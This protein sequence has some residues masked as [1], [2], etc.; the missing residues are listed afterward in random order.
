[1]QRP[2]SRIAALGATSALMLASFAG[3][4]ARTATQTNAAPASANARTLIVASD[5]SDGKTMD[6]GREYEFTADLVSENAYDRLITYK[7]SDTSHPVPD[8][9]SSWKVSNDAR[10]FT[11]HLRHDVTFFNG[12]KM[13]AADIVFSYRRLGYLN[14]NPAFLM[15]AVATGNKVTI[16]SVR[17]LNKYTVQFKLPTPDVSFLAALADVNFGVLDAKVVKAHGG[18]DAPNAATADKATTW[19]NN[20][21]AGTGPFVFTNW[22]RGAAGQIILKR[23]THYWGPR[24]FLNE[25]DIQ[26][27]KDTATQRLEVSKGTVDLA[28]NIDLDG[29]RELKSTPSVKVITGNTLDVVYM[30]MTMSCKVSKEMCNPKVRQAVRDAIDY[31]GI[32]NGL[33]NGVGTQPNGMIPV[34]M[35]GN[36]PAWNNSVKP[37]LN[38][39]AAK[40]L[41]KSAGYPNGFS[42]PLYY[43]GGVT[44]D[45]ISYDLIA[46]KVAND[47]AAVGIKVKL[48]PQEDTVLLPAYRA[49]KIPFILYNWGVDFPDPN[50]YAGPFGS[51]GGPATRMWF[52][53]NTTQQKLA[54]QADS[55]PNVA[56]RTALYHQVQKIWL[57][58]G[59]W[60]GLIQ[61]QGIVV[62]HQGVTGYTYNAVYGDNFRNIR[63]SA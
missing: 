12:D 11:F 4:A 32:I 60:V 19:L 37:K 13:T 16:D 35:L 34:G 3:I 43:D 47:L 14:D 24:P 20:H 56:K 36:S 59:P 51:G 10:F 48:T 57:S 9:A 52:T 21:S 8:L 38:V 27:V 17:A 41:L 58:Q 39:A 28:T 42:V 1:M 33:L 31:N 46:P 40:A 22:T 26:G 44:F 62:V 30:G 53:A 2:M 61:P 49:Q 63:K 55:T 18:S 15:G 50:D 54:V 25:I 5:I 6:P 23:N 29:A 45:G 7:G